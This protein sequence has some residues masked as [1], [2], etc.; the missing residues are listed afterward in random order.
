MKPTCEHDVNYEDF[1]EDC[2]HHPIE[3]WVGYPMTICAY[4]IRQWPCAWARDHYA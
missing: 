4:C 3:E 1:C 2:A